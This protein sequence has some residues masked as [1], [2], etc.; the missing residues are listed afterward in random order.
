MFQI[1]SFVPQNVIFSGRSSRVFIGSI[2]KLTVELPS[3]L[4]FVLKQFSLKTVEYCLDTGQY[5]LRRYLVQ[6]TLSTWIKRIN[7]DAF[8]VFR[9][10]LSASI[11]LV[12]IGRLHI[13]IFIFI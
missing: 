4:E 2:S 12:K 10:V 8:Y 1:F 11:F 9:T 7:V 13:S 3:Q 6:H 5:L